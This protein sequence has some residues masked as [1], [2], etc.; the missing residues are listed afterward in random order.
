MGY[1]YAKWTEWGG[2]TAEAQTD[3]G[4]YALKEYSG[5]SLG[6]GKIM[7]KMEP[8]SEAE[9]ERNKRNGMTTI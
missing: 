3:K 6:S 9:F 8:I 1:Y 2:T 4:E 5:V 7:L